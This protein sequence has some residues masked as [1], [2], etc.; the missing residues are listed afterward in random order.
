MITEH[1]HLSGISLWGLSVMVSAWTVSSNLLDNIKIL[2]KSTSGYC[3]ER[4]MPSVYALAH[5]ST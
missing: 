3:M 2:N 1:E 4:D 5:E